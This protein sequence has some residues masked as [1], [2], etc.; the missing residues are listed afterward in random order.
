MA[1]QGKAFIEVHA[2][3]KPFA[4]ELARE[5]KLIVTEF[6]KT[7]NKDLGRRLGTQVGDG[8]REGMSTAGPN[9]AKDLRDSLA[10]GAQ[11]AGGE[12]AD[13]VH[14][15]SRDGFDRT[16]REKSLFTRIA[17][18][19]ANALDDGISQLPM[20]LKAAIVA[21]LIIIAPLIVGAIGGALATAVALGFAGLGVGLATQFEQVKLEAKELGL[22]LRDTFVRAAEPIGAALVEIFA[23]VESRMVEFEFVMGRIFDELGPRLVPLADAL[24]DAALAFVE[25][26]EDGL[27]DPNFGRTIEMLAAGIRDLG[28]SA[29]YF[30]NTLLKDPETTAALED[31]LALVSSQI[32]AWGGLITVFSEVWQW[33]KAIFE[34]VFEL[35]A[36]VVNLLGN[37]VPNALRHLQDAARVVDQL[38]GDNIMRS[39]NRSDVAFGELNTTFEAT[40]ALTEGQAKALED[41]RKEQDKAVRSTFALF[42]A[43]IAYKD[44]LQDVTEALKENGRTFDLNTEKGRNNADVFGRAIEKLLQLMLL[45][46]ERGEMTAEEAEKQFQREIDALRKLFGT[47]KEAEKAFDDLLAS[48]ID[49]SKQ[50]ISTRAVD[51]LNAHAGHALITMTKLLAMMKRVNEQAGR[52]LPSQGR[53]GIAVP[54]ADGGI[55]TRPTLGLVGEAGDEVVIPLSNPGRAQELM[56]QS[57]LSSMVDQTVNVFIGNDQIDAYIDSRIGMYQRM[58]ARELVYGVR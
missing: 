20:Q 6:E 46:I 14:R 5:L 40:I 3:T 16:S 26:I 52:P 30:F 34:L 43:E 42:D 13:T 49:V 37:D 21:G 38:F 11:E 57:G 8:F 2:D 51:A 47:S 33:I 22:E 27:S 18:T 31:I 41:L 23:L 53:D 25:A 4:R 48:I 58:A 24:L 19:L 45:R 55:V 44:S 50:Q 35:G 10:D 12:I 39:A 1:I 36:F 32:R 15:S 54:Y 7:L 17:G 56:N 29:G 9:I 28:E